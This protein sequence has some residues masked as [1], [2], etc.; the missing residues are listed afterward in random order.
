MSSDVPRLTAAKVRDWVGERSARLGREYVED[1]AVSDATI[2]GRKLCAKV[3]GTAYQPYRVSV[4][5]DGDGVM[6]SADCS[7]P[8]GDGGGCKHV[9]AVL[10]AW[11]DDPS[12]FEPVEPAHKR[13]EELDKPALIAL[14]QQMLRREPDLEALLSMPLPGTSPRGAAKPEQFRKQAVAAM[15]SA[16]GEWGWHR[17][18]ADALEAIIETG[19]AFL[20]SGDAASAA[21]VFTGVVAALDDESLQEDE[22]GDIMGVVN[23]CA[24]GLARCLAVERDA[25]RRESILEAMFDIYLRDLDMGGVGIGDGVPED[26]MKHAS[27]EE[28]RLVAVWVRDKIPDAD[29]D[30]GRK[31]LGGFLLELEEDRLSDEAYLRACRQTGRSLDLIER[32]LKLNRDDE[33]INAIREMSDYE[34][35]Q[36]TDLLVESGRNAVAEELVNERSATSKDMRVFE[37][38]RERAVEHKDDEA[39]LKL[40]TKMYQLQPGLE[41]YAQVRALAQRLGRWDALRPKLLAGLGGQAR[42]GESALLV[43]I[44]LLEGDIDKALDLIK[45]RKR[46][47]TWP[48]TLMWGWNPSLELKVAAAA[49]ASRPEAAID[50]YRRAAERRIEHRNRGGYREACGLLAKVKEL[51]R[52]LARGATWDAYVADLRQRHKSLRALMQELET[53]GL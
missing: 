24:A 31:A 34:L 26:M 36:A 52:G 11:A 6:T 20:E 3:Q 9:G 37:W 33:A 38:L 12:S 41:R 51:Q 29:R 42:T 39:E 50:I 40:V 30:W 17:D 27:P 4:T 44:A 32:L 28:R 18:A 13:L 16:G 47:S 22:A 49:E 8:V 46:T 10:L 7:C 48:G 2:R 1:G 5:F 35:L 23:G 14:I 45:P 19:D 43:E 21:A 53:A 25:K 15:R